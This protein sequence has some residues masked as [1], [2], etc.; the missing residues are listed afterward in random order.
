MI[1]F[2]LTKEQEMVREVAREFIE[3]E[4]T[5]E[6]IKE[7]ERQHR[8][9]YEITKKMA[10]LGLTG[11]TVPQKYGGAGVDWVSHGLVSEEIGHAWFSLCLI[12]NMVQV[13]L[14]EMPI[15]WFGSE[16][17]KQKYLPPLVKAEKIGSLC[18]VEPAVGSDG[19]AV[20]TRAVLDGNYWVID[21]SKTWITNTSAADIIPV[22]CQTDESK[23]T[24]GLAMIIVERGVPGLSITDIEW[25]TGVWSAPTC[26][27]GLAGCR[28][29]KENLL[30]E[31]GRGFQ[32][33]MS[34]IN[35][36][37][38]GL[39]AGCTGMAQACIDASVKYAKE[40]IQF[41]KPI[42]SF[43]LMQEKIADMIV[44]TEA[45]RFLYLHVGYLKDKGLPFRRET[46]IAKIYA[47]ELA[48][49]ASTDAM[50]IHGAYGYCDEF[51][52]E[53]YFR[54][55]MAPT[56]FGGTNEM[57]RLTIGRDVLGIDAIR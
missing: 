37:R 55:V 47:T 9:P 30:G 27:V 51:P 1:D 20:K 26:E 32:I 43:Q 48:L 33:A 10:P 50:K 54:D 41:G 3:R 8:F 53:R 34:G 24:K 28:V 6:V 49:R 7:H 35:N 25:K 4:L 56:I 40:R 38:Y 36:V 19:T 29:P 21:G 57:H 39:S 15:V 2:E 31:V 46:S 22:L 14:V 23:G 45:S 11:T 17:Q 52:V 44:E 13:G 12:I 16:A 42:G 5:P 18:A